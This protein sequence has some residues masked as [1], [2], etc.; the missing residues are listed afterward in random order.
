MDIKPHPGNSFTFKYIDSLKQQN[1][2]LYFTIS[3]REPGRQRT[4]I[5]LDTPSFK[6]GQLQALEEAVNEKI[7]AHIPV[8]VQLLPVDDPALEKVQTSV[9]H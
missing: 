5:E 2:W 1:L 8:T 4:S 3:F 7:R 6:P 9:F